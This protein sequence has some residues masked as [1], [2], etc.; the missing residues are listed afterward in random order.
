MYIDTYVMSISLNIHRHVIMCSCMH[1][2][3][4]VIIVDGHT[5]VLGYTHKHMHKKYLRHRRMNNFLYDI[6]AINICA[7]GVDA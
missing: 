5:Y 4:N 6:N 1:F 7:C 2:Y 3:I